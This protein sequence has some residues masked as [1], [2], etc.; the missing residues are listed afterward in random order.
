M[1]YAETEDVAVRLMRD[2]DPKE[3]AFCEV[4]LDDIEAEITR[5]LGNS[6]GSLEARL[7]D[8]RLTERLLIRVESQ[9]VERVLRNPEGYRF[10]QDGDYS[11]S[12]GDALTEG[13]LGLTP[14][15]W[16]LLGAGS[17]AFTI[18]VG[19]VYQPGVAWYGLVR[20]RLTW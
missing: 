15:E 20:G 12:R 3:E 9:A 10:E 18:R 2:L 4:L 8:G 1:A 5:R 6:G 19:D 7:A 13:Q 11:Y 17:R 16:K 14:D